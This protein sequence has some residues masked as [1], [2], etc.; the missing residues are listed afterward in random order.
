M[1]LQ[2]IY[3][4][5][6][7]LICFELLVVFATFGDDRKNNIVGKLD[8]YDQHRHSSKVKGRHR[9]NYKT[10]HEKKPADPDTIRD[11]LK[12]YRSPKVEPKI[13]PKAAVATVQPTKTAEQQPPQVP[14]ETGDKQTGNHHNHT[15][16]GIHDEGNTKMRGVMDQM[17]MKTVFF[18]L[19]GISSLVIA[20]FVIR[21]VRSKG[22]RKTKKY[23]VLATHGSEVELRPLEQDDED[24]DM[25]VFD[26]NSH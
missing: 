2:H 21:I 7:V 20:Y 12:Q 3:Y 25:T 6:I 9:S 19:L 8:G 1:K 18:I 4:P 26:A 14:P 10:L 24:E 15:T 13:K 11:N 17:D 16:A 5:L 22:R 23:G